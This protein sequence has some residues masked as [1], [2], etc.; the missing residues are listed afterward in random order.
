MQVDRSALSVGYAVALV[1]E[2]MVVSRGFEPV[3][4]VT[5]N[6]QSVAASYK[7]VSP[8]EQWAL[9]RLVGNFQ[10]SDTPSDAIYEAVYEAVFGGKWSRAPE[11]ENSSCRSWQ[12]PGNKRTQAARTGSAR[13]RWPRISPR[14]RLKPRRLPLIAK[15]P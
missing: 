3:L 15:K 11:A 8:D 6:A 13:P 10:F 1:D 12:P 14:S 9:S 5:E 4:T 2:E 7:K